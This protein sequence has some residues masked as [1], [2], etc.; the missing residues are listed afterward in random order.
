[1]IDARMSEIADNIVHIPK[2]Y[3]LEAIP[4]STANN[5]ES[6]PY[7]QV[8]DQECY[9]EHLDPCLWERSGQSVRDEGILS[10]MREY[11]LRPSLVYELFLQG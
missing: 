11:C 10:M 6:K 5:P 4:S 9:T 2:F 8:V 7:A 3:I 1:M